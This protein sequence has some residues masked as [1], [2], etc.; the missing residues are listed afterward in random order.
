MS[1]TILACERKQLRR[2]AAENRELL[3]AAAAKVFAEQGLSAGVEEIARVAGV[4]VGTLYR[5]FP[6]KDALI[7]ELVRDV[8]ERMS[9]LASAAIEIP[10]GGGLE[11][12][13]E[14]SS[15][16]QMEHRGCLP[17]LWHTSPDNEALVQLRA[18]IATLLADAKRHGRVREEIT[19]TDLT[20]LMWSIRGVI[21][22]TRDV[23]PE[24]WRRHLAILVA[25]LRPPG[26]P[27]HHKPLTRAQVD[28]VL[29]D[30]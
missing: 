26:E 27:L 3:L 20:M 6:N 15:A 24:A 2:D 7:A 12:Y 19:A 23:A 11:H 5:R 30:S 17:R 14:G 1:T 13:L 10:D 21:E 8:L 18:K 29:T 16:Y 22:T 28:R 9:A 25:G 4:G